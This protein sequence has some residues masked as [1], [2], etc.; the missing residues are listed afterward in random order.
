MNFHGGCHGENESQA[1]HL[2]LSMLD[3]IVLP[4]LFVC[5]HTHTHTHKRYVVVVLV[6]L[7]LAAWQ[8]FMQVFSPRPKLPHFPG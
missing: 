2:H 4:W 5:T 6:L 1:F 7:K 3:K 8:Y